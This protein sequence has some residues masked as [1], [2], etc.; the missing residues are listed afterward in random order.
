[1]E[2]LERGDFYAS[3]G[4][5]LDDVDATAKDLTVKVQDRGRFEVPHPVHRPRWPG[6]ERGDRAVG[7]ATPSPATKATSARR[8]SRATAAWPGC[9]R[10]RSRTALRRPAWDGRRRCSS[11][12]WLAIAPANSGGDSGGSE[13]SFV[14]DRTIL[15]SIDARHVRFLRLCWGFSSGTSLARP[16][17]NPEA[18]RNAAWLRSLLSP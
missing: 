14:S 1:M 7:H 2:S 12:G 6:A 13:H 16:R 9:S 8:S 17:G 15:K 11:R 5:V 10:S 18:N 4:V 3:T